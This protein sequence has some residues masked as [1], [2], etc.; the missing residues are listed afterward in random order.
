M[1]LFDF[2][3]PKIPTLR[4]CMFGP[5]GVGKTTVLTSI[6]ADT[7]NTLVDSGLFFRYKVGSHSANLV[8]Y[9]SSLQQ[10]IIRRDAAHLPATYEISEFEFE[11]G[12]S[13]KVKANIVVKDYPGEYLTDRKE[14]VRKFLDESNVVIVAIDTPYLMEEDNGI[15]ND[16]KNNP[17]LIIDFIKNNPKSFENK[18]VLFVPLKCER[19][20]NDGRIDDVSH[21][22]GQVYGNLIPFFNEH[23]VASVVAP[24]K[25]LGGIEFDCME[26]NTGFGIP[27]IAKYRMYEND[28]NY[29]PRFC[30]QPMYYLMIY[31]ANYSEWAKDHASGFW[32]KLQA[33]I[34]RMFEN[35]EKFQTA[36]RELRTVILHNTCGYKLLT[37]NSILNF[38]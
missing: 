1:P 12:H 10:C 22:V 7:Q 2:I 29:K 4:I 37:N 17:Q 20:F 15:Y 5:R 32:A 6:F 33:I 8:G 18:L 31:G 21:R 34:A 28:P 11:L 30:A 3:T 25:T 36:L 38:N 27:V 26:R 35:D 19:Y 16:G 24:I 9:K 14:E 13:N 23:N